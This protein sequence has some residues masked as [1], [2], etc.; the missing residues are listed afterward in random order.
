MIEAGLVALLKAD[1]TVGPMVGD[2]ISPVALL[3]DPQ[4]PAIVYTVFP[5]STD[6]TLDGE[7]SEMTE[8]IR[9]CSISP[10]PTAAAALDQALHDLL[11][12]FSGALPGVSFPVQ[13][14]ERS[15]GADFFVQDARAY[16][17]TAE[18]VFWF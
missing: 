10:D 17:K 8:K 13:V 15:T 16:G 2:N 1:A 7:V 6:V 4:Y 12:T 11:D 5:S 14:I 3:P 9:I 18:F